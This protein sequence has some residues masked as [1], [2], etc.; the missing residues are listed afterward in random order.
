MRAHIHTCMLTHTYVQAHMCAHTCTCV[1]AHTCTDVCTIH[2]CMHIHT[3]KHTCTHA[4]VRTHTHI[5][6]HTYTHTRTH[7]CTRTHMLLDA[8][9]P[10]NLLRDHLSPKAG[11]PVPSISHHKG[12]APQIQ[13]CTPQ[14]PRGCS[15]Q[16][17][18]HVK[19]CFSPFFPKKKGLKLRILWLALL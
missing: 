2:M 19:H 9:H 3:C 16:L 7:T 10:N 8:C 18:S 1:S 17:N 14:L 5:H 15:L 13:V 11:C 6:T 4:R 12:P